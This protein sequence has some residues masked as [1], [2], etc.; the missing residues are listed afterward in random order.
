MNSF[1][2]V[3]KYKT[4]GNNTNNI[5][6]GFVSEIDDEEEGLLLMSFLAIQVGIRF[7]R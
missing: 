6:S 7:E 4:T 5:K 2:L 3:V 1:D